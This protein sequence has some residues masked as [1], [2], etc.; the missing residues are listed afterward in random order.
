LQL[1]SSFDN[2]PVFLFNFFNILISLVSLLISANRP[3]V[4]GVISPKE[5]Q[6]RRI[7]RHVFKEILEDPTI[8][9]E[10][11]VYSVPAQPTDQEENR[12]L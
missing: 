9:N 6:A 7:L 11:V 10:K 8:E 2:L 12:L 4:R 5:K 3:L 1:E